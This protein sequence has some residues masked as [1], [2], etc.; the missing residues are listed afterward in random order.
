MKILLVGGAGYLGGALTDRLIDS[1]HDVCVYD[2]LLYEE[3]YRKPVRFVRGDVRDRA[4]LQKWLDWADTVVWLAAVVGDPACALN[5]QLTTEINTNSVG[6]LASHFAGRI[7]FLSSCSVYGAA[8]G[9]LTESSELNPLS[10]YAKTKLWSEQV[11]SPHP[12][13][14][15]FRLGTL[16]GA[17]DIFSRIRFDLVVNTLVMRAVLHNKVTVFGGAQY[18]PL[19][20]VRDAAKTIAQHLSTSKTGVFNLHGENTTI[21]E[22][23]ERIREHFPTVTIEMT[24]TRFQDN[25]NYSVSSE[26]ATA[27][28]DFMPEYII[29]DGMKEL[30]EMLM[31]GRIKDTF[32]NRFSN[33]LYLRPLLT[34]YQSPLGKVVRL[35][36]SFS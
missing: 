21:I 5:E 19:L 30:K 1:E 29:N 13:S 6:Y 3:S 32:L 26:K 16:Y 35:N 18:R 34:E 24:Q 12:H 22:I 17:S 9:I 31:E 14:L 15:I 33:Y 11:L 2:V 25:R 23:A 36:A 4:L 27:Q 8:D 10:L 7:I 28:L 20:H